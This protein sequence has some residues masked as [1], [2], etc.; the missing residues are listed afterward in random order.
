MTQLRAFGAFS[1]APY[2]S[3]G[4]RGHAGPLT[5]ARAF[6]AFTGARYGAFSG[7]TPTIPTPDLPTERV[8]GLAGRRIYRVPASAFRQPIL[9]EDELIVAICAAAVIVFN[10]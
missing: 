10:Q 6:G 3:F 7:R 9:D 4:R 5:Q 1:G 2:G 8:I